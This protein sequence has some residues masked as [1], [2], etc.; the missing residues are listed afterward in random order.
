MANKKSSSG[1]TILWFVIAIVAIISIGLG[2]RFAGI[3]GQNTNEIEVETDIA[4]LKTITQLVSSSGKIQPEI[5]VI[6][7]PDVSGEIIELAVREGDFVRKGDLL[8]RIKPDIYQARIDELNAALLTQKARYEQANATLIQ[9]ESAYN[10]NKELYDR[11]V[12]SESDFIQAKS[13]YNAQKANLSASEYQIQSAQAQLR[14][15]KEELQQ[16]VIRAPQDGTITGLAVELGERVLGNSQ[17]A[18]TDMMRISF[19][20]KME[21]LVEVNENDIVKVESQDSVRIEVDAYPERLFKGVVTEIANSA[22]VTGT[23]SNEQVTNY[24]VKVRI[25]TPHNLNMDGS[26]LVMKNASEDP[27][28]NFVPNFKPGMSATVDIETESAINIVSVP[29][30]AVTIRDF[31][32]DKAAKKD[33]EETDDIDESLIVKKEDLRKVVFIVKGGKAVRTEVETGISDNSHIQI[34]AGVE[35]GDEIVIG[36]YRI[37]SNVLKDGD[38][39]TNKKMKTEIA[40][41]K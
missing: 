2:L 31:S 37:L 32:K 21:V 34:L 26:N 15:A 40:S 27:I 39:V 5:E 28:K 12:I 7:R 11:K 6:I 14:R 19:L 4:K 22:R 29:I 24:Q 17:M 23:G 41:I 10:K 13:N 1:K 35:A 9:A 33:S 30:Q 18:G 20:D 3:I 16:T 38:S 8:L 36:S 25:K